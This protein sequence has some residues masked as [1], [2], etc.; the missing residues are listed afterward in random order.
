MIDYGKLEQIYTDKGIYALQLE[1]GDTCSQAC[2]YCYMNALPDEKNSLSDDQ[3][4]DIL[5]G[6]C[7]LGI[8][9]IEWLGGEPLLRSSVFDHM[10]YAAE[11]RL[12]NN[13]WTGGLPLADRSIAANCAEYAQNGLISIH[14]STVNDKLYEK[15]HPGRTIKDRDDIIKGIEYLLELGYPP[16]QMLNSVTFT[17]KQPAEDMIETMDFFYDK[18]SV[19]TSLNV[20]HTYLRPG[21]DKGE[22]EKFIPEESETGKVY[23]HFS[24][25]WG[26]KR[27]PMNCVNKQYCS[28]TAA[29]LCDGSVTPCATI[30]DSSAESIH[31]GI[32]FKE[33]VEENIGWLTFE[34]M[35]NDKVLPEDCRKCAITDDCWGCRSRAYAAGKGIY[36]K[37][38]RCFRKVV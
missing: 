22:L 37:D 10:A 16:E 33:I 19:K 14:C 23:K 24:K 29:V 20:Y 15:L 17:G 5:R 18:Y 2:S 11:L 35:K 31:S 6:S 34:Y 26:L 3:I 7:E 27:F 1:I 21:M 8:V 30:R 13:I 4:K 25:Q 12:K 36:G 32:S 28:A 38:P 9:A